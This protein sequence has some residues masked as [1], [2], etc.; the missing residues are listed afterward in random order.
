MAKK[1]NTCHTIALI[2][3]SYLFVLIAFEVETLVHT[4]IVLENYTFL[5]T[6]NIK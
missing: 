1:T 5:Q 4:Y 3:I 6:K 2:V